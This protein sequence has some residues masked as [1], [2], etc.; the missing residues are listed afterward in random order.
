[1]ADRLDSM[2]VK[3]SSPDG[4]ITG[5]YRPNQGGVVVDFAGDG[6]R[7]Y[8]ERGLERQLA[9]VAQRFWRGYRTAY[10]RAL[11]EATGRPTTHGEYWEADRR[12]YWAE[13]DATSYEGMSAGECVYFH[14]VG[15]RDFNVVIR[16]GWL[17]GS[18]KERFAREVATGFSAMMSDYRTKLA[19]LRDKHY[20]RGR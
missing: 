5:E 4:L 16:D 17:A 18:T 2:V 13:R 6:F 19:R 3:V 11:A 15:L 9:A 8:R 14:S 1:M 10:D 12:R 7:R 20:G